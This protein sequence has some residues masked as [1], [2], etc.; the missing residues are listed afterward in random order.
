[1]L[2]GK[3]ADLQ[4]GLAVS[5][6]WSE[7]IRWTVTCGRYEDHAPSGLAAP[8]TALFLFLDPFGYSH[9]P[10]TLR[11]LGSRCLGDTDVAFCGYESAS[12]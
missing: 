10:M 11:H 12:A 5:G 8:R 9:G 6:K 1:M 2:E 7:R 3:L 4:A